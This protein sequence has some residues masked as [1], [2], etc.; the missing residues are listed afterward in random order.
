MA[1]EQTVA[2]ANGKLLVDR[3]GLVTRITFNK[4]EK[5]NAM[6]L[7]MWD[8][9]KTVLDEMAGDDSVRVVILTGAGDKA[10]VSGADISEFESQRASEEGIKTYNAISEAADAA[11]YHFPKPTIAEIQGYCIGGGMGLAAGCDF[12]ICSEDS[13]MGITAARLGLGYNLAGVRKLVDL[14]GPKVAARVLYAA[15]LFPAEKALSLGLVDE[16][17]SKEQLRQTVDALAGRIANNAP[18]TIKTAKA[19]IRA[20]SAAE[21]SPDSADVAK[22]VA[23]CFASSDYIEGRR[24]FAE[25]RRPVFTGK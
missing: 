8:G 24:A 2:L 11:L 1:Q 16:V 12:R 22:L 7:D 19:A 9:L 21:G 10:F 25:K 20:S 17:V 15:E 18:L 3:D 13:R 4:P 23:E 6:S 5:M 14:A